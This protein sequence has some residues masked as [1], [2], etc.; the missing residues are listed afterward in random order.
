MDPKAAFDEAQERVKQLPAQPPK[1]L[2][3]LYGLY[4]QAIE[5]DVKGARPGML[6]IRGR[7]KY[8][9]WA[10]IKGMSESEA[11]VAYSEYVT[12]LEGNT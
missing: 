10:F 12:R 9:A 8:D 5:G 11:M 7:A 2:L 1:V 6:D 4:K 3:D